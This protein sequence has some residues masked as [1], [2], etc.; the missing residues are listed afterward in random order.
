VQKRK[1][2]DQGTGILLDRRWWTWW[3]WWGCCAW[4]RSRGSAG[5]WAEATKPRGLTTWDV[6]GT[7]RRRSSCPPPTFPR[8]QRAG[9]RRRRRKGATRRCPRARRSD[10]RSPAEKKKVTPPPRLEFWNRFCDVNIMRWS[11]FCAR[12]KLWNVTIVGQAPET[13]DEQT[14]FLSLILARNPQLL[15]TRDRSKRPS[16]KTTDPSTLEKRDSNV[17]LSLATTL[18]HGQELRKI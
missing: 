2:E 3:Q 10:W 16:I 15:E 1:V 18:D 5:P 4:R 6:R 9:P 8:G 13:N 11:L 14:F 7:L 17:V 12:W